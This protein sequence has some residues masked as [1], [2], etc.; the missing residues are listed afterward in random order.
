LKPVKPQHVR[1]GAHT[2][3]AGVKTVP[4]FGR[5]TRRVMSATLPGSPA[6]SDRVSTVRVGEGAWSGFA[7]S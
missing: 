4:G 7:M 5:R 1:T 3:W 2:N 6:G